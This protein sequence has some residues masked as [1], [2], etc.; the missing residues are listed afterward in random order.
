MQKALI[1]TLLLK[2]QGRMILARPLPAPETEGVIVI[3][4]KYAAPHGKGPTGLATRKAEVLAVGKDVPAGEVKAGDVVL[5]NPINV[6]EEIEDAGDR[7][8]FFPIE[9]VL[10]VYEKE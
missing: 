2:P 10:V 7:G 4:P 1:G 8:W 9:A 5:L 3:P 6:E